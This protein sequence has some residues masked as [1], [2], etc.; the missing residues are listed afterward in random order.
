MLHDFI[1]SWSLFQNSYLAGYLIA[2]LLALLGVLIVARDQIFLGAAVT[3]ASTLGIALVLWLGFDNDLYASLM[4]VAFS[5]VASVVTSQSSGKSE[6]S[7][8]SVTGW[9]FLFS[10][11]AAIL[12]VAHSPHGLEEVHRLL[13]SSIIGAR[14]IDV[15]IFALT[16]A[17][18][19]VF[20]IFHHRRFCLLVLDPQTAGAAG[21][22]VGLWSL[23][24]AVWLGLGIGLSL[25][26]S[27]MLYTF[28]CLVLPA[29]SAK[30]L[31]REVRQMFWVS[32]L[33][34]L[35]TAG[36]AFI[37]A[38]SY[39]VPPAPMTVALQ[40]LLFAVIGMLRRAQRRAV[41]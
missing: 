39:D 15:W 9:V 28:G 22:Q 30:C 23:A 35:S 31:C 40:A 36:V 32:P 5:V 41:A 26:T 7:H 6:G 37:L 3:Q 38:N 33:L 8:E 21:M 13:S 16:S 17:L 20:L 29:L 34:S 14:S 11:A 27:G 10:A 24:L 25:R 2:V 12:V 18:T 4:A 1:N 19:A